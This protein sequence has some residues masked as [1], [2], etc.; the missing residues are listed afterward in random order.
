MS[1][2]NRNHKEAVSPP[3]VNPLR[4]IGEGEVTGD[5]NSDSD[6][7]R[8]SRSPR[9]EASRNLRPKGS[10]DAAPEK[11]K[12]DEESE[13]VIPEA[14]RI[15]NTPSIAE[16]MKHQVTH[17]PFQDWCPICVK[18]A[19]KNK[20]HKKNTNEREAEVFNL[21]YMYMTSKPTQQELAHPILIIKARVSGGFGR[22]QSHAKG[23]T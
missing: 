17:Y 14:K 2:D 6:S 22:Y 15:P 11:E 9:N 21:D 18:N 16:Y 4:R 8:R 12:E 23:H 3:V 19:A 1:C 10:D 7:R 20:P 13:I 5:T